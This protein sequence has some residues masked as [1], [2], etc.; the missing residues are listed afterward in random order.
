M[1]PDQ[2]SEPEKSSKTDNK[3]VQD[4]S[5]NFR[6]GNAGNRIFLRHCFVCKKDVPETFGV[7]GVCPYCGWNEK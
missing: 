2:P 7:L 1:Q 3:S 5:P 6:I 4:Q